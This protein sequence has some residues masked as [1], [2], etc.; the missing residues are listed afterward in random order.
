MSQFHNSE[1]ACIGMDREKST[2]DGWEQKYIFGDHGRN[3]Q[4][5]DSNIKRVYDVT[6][7]W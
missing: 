7:N 2:S 5:K 6:L 1:I 4:V 3:P